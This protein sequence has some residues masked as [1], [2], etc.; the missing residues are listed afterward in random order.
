[1][2]GLVILSSLDFPIGDY[3]IEFEVKRIDRNFFRD[4]G[5][6]ADWSRDTLRLARGYCAIQT[7]IKKSK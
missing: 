7:K 3:M 6:T 1:M 4:P 5:P 2:I